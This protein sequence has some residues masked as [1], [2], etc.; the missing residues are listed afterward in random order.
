MDVAEARPGRD[1]SRG[2][3]GFGDRGG[4]G[5]RDTGASD[6][7][8]WLEARGQAQATRPPSMNRSYNDRDR[9]QGGDRSYG[10]RDRGQGGDRG[11]GSG[12]GDRDRGQ[13][14]DRSSYGNRDGGD[15]GSYGSRW[16]F[17]AF[18][19]CLMTASD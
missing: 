10:D 12:Y 14:G 4:Y 9:G 2:G 8:N 6:D 7:S 15:R 19:C 5:D 17:A 1:D 11:Y 3:R 16:G 18:L 13:G